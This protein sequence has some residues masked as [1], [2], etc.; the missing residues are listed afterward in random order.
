MF[1]KKNIPI[2]ILSLGIIFLVNSMANRIKSPLESNNNDELIK[3]Y[4][5]NDSPLYGNNRPKLWIHSKYEVNSRKWKDFYSRNTTDLNQEYIHL[6]IKTIINHCGEDF[7]ICLIDD[8]SFSKLLPDWDIDLVRMAEPNKSHYRS[9]GMAQLIYTYGGMTVPNSLICMRGLKELY[10]ENIEHKKSFVC[11]TINRTNNI[12]TNNKLYIPSIEIMGASKN[13]T[14]ILELV[15]YIK[16]IISNSHYT[17]EIDFIGNIQ[18]K[19]NEMVQAQKMNLVNGNRIGI[20]SSKGKLI[21]IEDLCEEAYLDLSPEVI[22]LYI[23][24]TDVLKRTKYNWLAV[25]SVKELLNSNII[26]S[27]YLKTSIIDGTDEYYKGTKERTV[28]TI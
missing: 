25:I 12:S 11:E 23:P 15:E 24:S 26:L 3:N 21:T 20:K 7:N 1:N 14:S 4:I 5:L 18:K 13:D 17:N 9:L 16:K 10:D 8:A 28:V 27:K 22:G 6:T 2:Y 19:C